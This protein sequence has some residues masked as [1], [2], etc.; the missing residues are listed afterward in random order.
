LSGADLVALCRAAAMLLIGGRWWCRV[1]T[2]NLFNEYWIGSVKDT[3][4]RYCIL[5]SWFALHKTVS[6]ELT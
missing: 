3:D 5:C 6:E 1:V 4:L 2:R